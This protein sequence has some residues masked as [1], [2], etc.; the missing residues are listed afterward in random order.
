MDIHLTKRKKNTK[1]S[2]TTGHSIIATVAPKEKATYALESS[3][4]E[5]A[6]PSKSKTSKSQ[7]IP[8]QKREDKRLPLQER[9]Q[10]EYSFTKEN[11][12]VL[13][14]ELIENNL[15]NVLEPRHPKE[16]GRMDGPKYFQLISHFIGD[17][18]VLKGKLQD[19]VDNQLISLPLTQ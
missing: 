7:A 6:I 5:K 11:V 8:R 10:P 15:L 2:G 13:F 12:L 18:F 3:S 19:L 1:E 17:C 4:S 9:Q 16:V 14:D